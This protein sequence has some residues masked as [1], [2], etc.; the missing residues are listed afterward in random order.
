MNQDIL[1]E[2]TKHQLK[3]EVPLFKVGDEV[4]VSIKVKEGGKERIQKFTGIV[5]ARK[6]SGISETFTVRRVVSDFS[7]ERV[8]HL[9]APNISGIKVTKE[10][11]VLDTAKWYKSRKWVGKAASQVREK[12]LFAK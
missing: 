2:V 3:A 4:C 11:V 7:V 12:R 5:I 10:S 6:G 8:F 9:H 1:R